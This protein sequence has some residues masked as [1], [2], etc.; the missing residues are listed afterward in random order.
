M[1]LL[2]VPFGACLAQTRS[3]FSEQ[4]YPMLQKA[5]CRTCHFR[6]GVAS[7]TRLRFPDDDAQTATLE[8]FGRSLVEFVDRQEPAKSLLWNKPT[9]RIAHTGGERIKRGGLHKL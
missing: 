3:S 5:G 4:V 6:D 1:L 9:L 2:C 7:A 8:A